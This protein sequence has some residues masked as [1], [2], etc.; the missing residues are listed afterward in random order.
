M[1]AKQYAK[2]AVTYLAYEQHGTL[3]TM[4]LRRLITTALC[5]F[6][7]GCGPTSGKH[8]VRVVD[9]VSSSAL[10]YGQRS[11]S[12]SQAG[13]NSQSHSVYIEPSRM[14]PDL[15]T[16]T[17]VAVESDG[18]KLFIVSQMRIRERPDGSIQIATD[19][20]PGGRSKVFHIAIPTR[21]NG[22]YMFVHVGSNATLVWRAADWLATL[23]PVIKVDIAC[24]SVQPGFDRFYLR[25]GGKI[26]PFDPVSQQLT[27]IGSLPMP[28]GSGPMI[29]ADAWRGVATSDLRGSL[30]TFDAGRTWVPI[31]LAQNIDSLRVE[32]ESIIITTAPR[33]SSADLA[34]FV[35]DAAGRLAVIDVPDV[36]F[37]RQV[38][39]ERGGTTQ[40][41]LPKIQTKPRPIRLA[42]ERGYPLTSSRVLVADDGDLIEVS[43]DDGSVVSVARRAYQASLSDCHGIALGSGIGFVCGAPSGPTVVYAYE[44]PRTMRQVLSY[45]NPVAVFSSG[46]GA[47]VVRSPCPNVPRS[48]ADPSGPPSN[49]LSERSENA[50]GTSPATRTPYCVREASGKLREI[51]YQG[52]S[53]TERLAVMA[54]GRVVIIEAQQHGLGAR[55]SIDEASGVGLGTV[56]R[57]ISFDDLTLRQRE[58]VG[59][60]LWMH[61]V[62]EIEPGVLGLWVD[63]GNEVVG[64]RID[65]NGKAI[66]GDIQTVFGGASVAGRVGIVSSPNA[67]GRE[68]ETVDGGMTWSEIESTKRTSEGP[69]ALTRG[70]SL[71]GCVVQ[72]W[73][74]VGWGETADPDKSVAAPEPKVSRMQPARRVSL[75]YSCWPTG[76][77]SPESQRNATR[78][79]A[80]DKAGR[81]TRVDGVGLGRSTGPTSSVK[82]SASPSGIQTRVVSSAAT[83]SGIPGIGRSGVDSAANAWRP[84]GSLPLPT[85]AADDLG[86]AGG[87]DYGEPRMLAFAWGPA[88]ADW[89]RT[90]RWMVAIDNPYDA[91]GNPV[92]S[93]RV[94]SPWPDAGTAALYLNSFSLVV[95]DAGRKSAVVGTCASFNQCRMFAV[96]DGQEPLELVVEGNRRMPEV[97]SVVHTQE[98]W[99]M[100]G[101]RGEIASLYVADASGTV[102]LL[103]TYPRYRASQVDEL[104]LVRRAFTTGVALWVSSP[105]PD[106]VRRAYVLPIDVNTGELRPT[107]E[108]WHTESAEREPSRCLAGEDGWLVDTVLSTHP[109]FSNG[110]E[111][112][113]NTRMIVRTDA[114]RACV[115][116]ISGRGVESDVLNAPRRGTGVEATGMI[117]MVIWDHVKDSK[118]ELACVPQPHRGD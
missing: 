15:D 29:F 74:R 70:C 42:I 41:K 90:G 8:V 92:V 68:R 14:V 46:N 99:F 86:L 77:R 71:V 100:L 55:M 75:H 38:R 102:R 6:A 104:R 97:E 43:V 83:L 51:S 93:S 79:K 45:A 9:T 11:I 101:T 53:G 39:A 36:G 103:G 112:G 118:Y 58:L 84:F 111:A 62:I 65:T 35:L 78:D 91:V 37:A 5:L 108:V 106:G 80:K 69:I 27:T 66:A 21:F 98:G 85:L 116:A 40:N 19:R 89:H 24:D 64:L 47:L 22:G 31:G 2:T 10:I 113:T 60:G 50:I 4:T 94:A 34:R 107:L 48:S 114:G 72:G 20:L 67:A 44:P 81:A 17:P 82:A 52:G 12:S 56:W 109:R 105:A 76:R 32:N 63:G 59:R 33:R 61:G 13:S 25:C 28:L 73:L 96:S 95:A 18:T 26:L 110:T 3:P 16:S 117:P 115:E 57:S 87:R 49:N 7:G 54:D 23:E 1:C 30:A 88:N